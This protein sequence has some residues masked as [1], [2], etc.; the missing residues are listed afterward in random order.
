MR[1]REKIYLPL[2]SALFGIFLLSLFDF[3][4]GR[5]LDNRRY[6]FHGL[7]GSFRES[8]NV[9]VGST[10]FYEPAN[11]LDGFSKF[12]PIRYR[13]KTDQNG[14]RIS[15]LQLNQPQSF[16][17]VLLGDSFV[18]G[19]GL[20]WRETMAGQL[21]KR[22]S[23]NVLNAGVESYSPTAY[24]FRLQ[25]LLT[26][27]SIKSGSPVVV[28]VDISD[29]QDEATAWFSGSNELNYLTPPRRLKS[30]DKSKERSLKAKI[31]ESFPLTH[32]FL[33]SLKSRLSNKTSGLCSASEP[34]DCVV[35]LDRS[36]FTFKDNLE[37]N[38]SYQPLGISRG[39][40]KLKK[41]LTEL[42]LEIRHQGLKAYVLSYPWPAQV[43]KPTSQLDWDGLLEE[44]CLAAKCAGLIS[45]TSI[46]KEKASVNPEWY[47][48][49]Y[50]KGDM[51]FNQA[52]YSLLVNAIQRTLQR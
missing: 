26:S 1:L 18:W 32:A 46:F 3:F 9:L 14:F 2:L 27:Y 7:D 52:G 39:A 48:A 43:I 34:I 20:P 12:G 36:A 6:K 10:G 11:N 16:D 28:S 41:Q 17:L 37:L 31:I 15:E 30:L 45:T 44:S 21:E 49:Y 33:L 50:I 5:S 13:V 4:F 23:I 8:H 22:L 42:L 51:H 47:Q 24:R 38:P 35:S 29:L 25:K 19:S 40:A